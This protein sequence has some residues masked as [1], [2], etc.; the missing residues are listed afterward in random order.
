[1]VESELQ[2]IADTQKYIQQ[3]ELLPPLNPMDLLPLG[4]IQTEVEIELQQ[5]LA[6]QK[7]TQISMPL[8]P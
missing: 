2:L 1:M 3:N 7:Y 5:I 8:L 4:E 6:I